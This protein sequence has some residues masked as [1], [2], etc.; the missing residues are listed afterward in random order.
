MRFFLKPKSGFISCHLYF[1]M[2]IT[3]CT[4][5]TNREVDQ[6]IKYINLKKKQDFFNNNK[7]RI[8]Q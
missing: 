7:K 3:H 6:I 8:S 5:Q 1:P 4:L 2:S